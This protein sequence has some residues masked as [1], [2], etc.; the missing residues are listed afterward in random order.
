MKY[1]EQNLHRLIEEVHLRV[2]KSAGEPVYELIYTWSKQK[3]L[4]TVIRCG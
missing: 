2:P 3:I 1:D 4:V